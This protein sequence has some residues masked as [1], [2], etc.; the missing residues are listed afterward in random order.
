MHM[1]LKRTHY[2]GL[3]TEK[4]LDKKVVI[5]GW[6][7]GKR[8]H[9]GLIFLDL[10]DRYGIVQVVFDFQGNASFFK[11][12]EKLRPEYVLAI[13]GT[14][15]RRSP[16]TVNP[17]IATGKLEVLAEDM[18]IYNSS[19]T[20]PFY[21]EDGIDTDENL[22]LKYRFLD[23]RRFEM[24]RSLEI[25]H[26]T[27]MSV[28]RFLDERGFWEIE[29]PMLTRS[30]PEGARD[31]LVPSRT[32][33]GSF[34]ALPQSPQ[35]FKQLL[36]TSGVEKY[37]QITRCFRDEDLRADRQPEFTQIDIEMSFCT[38]R[39]VIIE[40]EELVSCLFKEV[41]H[42][43]IDIPLEIITYKEAMER[44]GS[45][46]PDT[47]FDME[48]GD[49]SEIAGESEFRVFKNVLKKDGVVKGLNVRGCGH[50]SRKELDDL[51]EL[52]KSWG[53]AGLAWIILEEDGFRTPISKFFTSSQLSA[54]KA[55]MQGKPGDLLLFVADQ[56]EVALKVL[57]QLRIF[58]AKRLGLVPE[59]EDHFLWVVDFPLLAYD[60][61]EKR[62]VANHHPFTAP[63]TEDLD[64]LEK[65]P[66]AVRSQAYDLVYNGVEIAG[67]SIRVHKKEVQEKIFNMLGMN[68]AE[69]EERFGFFLNAFEYGIPPHGGIAFGLDRL[70]MLM[71]GKKS[72]R[73]VIPFPKTAGG[74]CLLTGAPAPILPKQLKELHISTSLR[75][76]KKEKSAA[77][78][79][80][81]KNT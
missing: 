22:R 37:F 41:L 2:C 1:R 64:L 74:T 28:R 13:K 4:D 12:A 7:Q 15:K 16:E 54:I 67:G 24:Q 70:V 60:S 19:L 18:E 71:A 34:F 57:G 32:S 56:W 69:A 55:R 49:I 17:N 51:T 38:S 44:F 68:A 66:L 26:K 61:E 80:F 36:M 72:I 25:R 77:P 73:D 47:R 29:T 23:L 78:D 79:S 5:A 6:V 42:K 63:F 8:D 48:I 10:R 45:D 75:K 14:I 35:L 30:T 21:I 43:E 62:Y 46:K 27:M 20:P 81:T 40:T 31:F 33:P 52:V 11:Q 9:G 59:N 39:D 53:T 65:D 50:F 76:N 3:I 58:L